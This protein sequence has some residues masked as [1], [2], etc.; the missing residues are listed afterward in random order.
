MVLVPFAEKIDMVH[1][2]GK[3]WLGKKIPKEPLQADY[4]NVA[5]RARKNL[6][7]NGIVAIP[8]ARPDEY[9]F[10]E[11]IER[12]TFLSI[13]GTK[14]CSTKWSG[15]SKVNETNSVVYDGEN[16]VYFIKAQEVKTEL[17]LP[18][19]KVPL[20]FLAYNLPFG[21]NLSDKSA[22][23]MLEEANI[24]KCILGLN[25]PSCFESVDESLL[26]LFDLFGK[27]DFVVGYAGGAAL[28]GFG[29]ANFMAQKIY[30][31]DIENKEFE[32]PY[33]NEKHKIGV[34][35]VSGGHRTPNGFLETMLNGEQTVGRSYTEIPKP[36]PN[37]FM[38]DLRQSLR[39]ST[40]E[41]MHCKSIIIE[42][43]KSRLS[44]KIG[45]KIKDLL[46]G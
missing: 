35:A 42:A 15:L 13:G 37:N 39:N 14:F 10:E 33:T 44:I 30:E 19:K 28:K 5:R 23:L 36:N 12:D 22:E 1:F 43:V 38:N 46:F 9:R 2:D 26:N 21:K 3:H 24:Y 29:T 25:L 41:N 31:D 6:G 18:H 4:I 16:E 8:N 40:E 7:K 34:I 17:E 45:D 11:F 20:V 32:N 27:L